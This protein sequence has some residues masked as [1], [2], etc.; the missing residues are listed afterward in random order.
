MKRLRNEKGQAFLEYFVLTL[1]VLVAAAA[2]YR[3][4]SFQGTTASIDAAF[5]AKCAQ[6][7]GT[8]C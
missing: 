3:N 8:G 1:I 2:F 5:Q 7:A 6:I 4:G